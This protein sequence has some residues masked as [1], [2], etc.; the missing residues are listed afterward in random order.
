MIDSRGSGRPVCASHGGLAAEGRPIVPIAD[1]ALLERL[2]AVNL[3]QASALRSVRT[4]IGDQRVTNA[5]AAPDS[6]ALDAGPAIRN[7][8]GE[9]T[10]PIAP[11]PTRRCHVH[12]DEILTA[13]GLCPTCEPLANA[14]EAN[15]WGHEGPPEPYQP[16]GFFD[17]VPRGGRRRDA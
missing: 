17:T 7:Q 6:S 10:R 15:F 13:T 2:A 3:V 1:G 12:G 14:W 4:R 8:R 5:V 16:P 11:A 9:V